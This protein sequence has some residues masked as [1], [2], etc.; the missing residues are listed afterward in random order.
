MF[1]T[2]I[3]SR[4]GH[5]MHAGET[6]V[7]TI[8]HVGLVAAAIVVTAQAGRQDEAVRTE[9]I[10]FSQP[11]PETPKPAEEAPA[12]PK[13]AVLAPPPPKGFQTLVAPVNIPDKIPDVDLSRA[14]TNE[15]DFSGRGVE[16]GIAKGVAGGTPQNISDQPYFE[17][18]VEKT[19]MARDGN[20]VPK[21]P[22][23]LENA[24]A[25]GEV[26]AQFVVDTAGRVESGSA[27]ILKSSDA[28]FANAVMNVLPHLRFYAAEVGGH[29]VRAIVQVPFRFV[30]PEK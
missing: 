17:F 7:S 2:L 28:L 22:T 8:L 23:L 20:P 1:T 18:Q 4:P 14:V 29:K 25:T 11:T 15:D 30:A 12:P 21:Y 16:G 6:L 9:N 13:D 5:Q 10:I 24:K 3:E 19:V 26:L 27:R